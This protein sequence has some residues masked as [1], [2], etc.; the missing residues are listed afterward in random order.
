MM[1]HAIGNT[2][3][4]IAAFSNG[5]RLIRDITTGVT[6]PAADV[7]PLH[8]ALIELAAVPRLHV[9]LDD[10]E[11]KR[12]SDWTALTVDDDGGVD[13]IAGADATPCAVVH[14]G[15]GDLGFVV[16]GLGQPKQETNDV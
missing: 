15:L 1:T 6:I 2:K 13:L 7:V 4:T 11:L 3:I 10:I 12:I 14:I 9:R 16:G 8:A 5:D